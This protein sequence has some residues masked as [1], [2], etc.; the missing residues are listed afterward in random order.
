MHIVKT[1]GVT[2]GLGY[3][4]KEITGFFIP[5][6]AVHDGYVWVAEDNIAVKKEINVIKKD[7]DFAIVSGDVSDGDLII[8]S[9]VSDGIKVQ[10]KK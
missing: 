1:S 8:L 3:A 7:A 2:D 6:N 9:D 10:I 4:E 5:V